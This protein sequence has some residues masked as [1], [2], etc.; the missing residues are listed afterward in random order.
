[1]PIRCYPSFKDKP[2]PAELLT[3]F[4]EL[5]E[6]ALSQ[7]EISHHQAWKVLWQMFAAPEGTMTP[8]LHDLM[9]TVMLAAQLEAPPKVLLH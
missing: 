4:G 3:N 5:L 6:P 2:M 7:G 1:M 8:E 9:R